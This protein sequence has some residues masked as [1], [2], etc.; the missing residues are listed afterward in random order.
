MPF[1][2]FFFLLLD[3]NVIAGAPAAI[4]DDEVTLGMKLTHVGATDGN[5]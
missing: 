2:C 5:S 1:F 4:F 3:M